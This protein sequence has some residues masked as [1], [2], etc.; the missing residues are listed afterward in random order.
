MRH[1]PPP[2]PLHTPTLNSLHTHLFKFMHTPTQT[3]VYIYSNKVAQTMMC[4]VGA[5]LWTAVAHADLGAIFAKAS[6]DLT[7]DAG[8]GF[9]I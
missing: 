2:I 3:H 6:T 4:A 9:R 7:F 8:L 5:L 1:T